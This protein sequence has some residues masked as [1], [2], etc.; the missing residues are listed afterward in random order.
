MKE[1][2][3][4]EERKRVKREINFLYIIEGGIDNISNTADLY[5]LCDGWQCDLDCPVNFLC[6]SVLIRIS[7][8][9]KIG[10][11]NKF[12]PLIIEYL[13]NKRD[14]L[15]EKLEEHKD[16]MQSLDESIGHWQDNVEKI[17]N[18]IDLFKEIKI[19][20]NSCSLCEFND[21]ING[22]NSCIVKP[23]CS[24]PES[25]WY[26]VNIERKDARLHLWSLHSAM[27]DMLKSLVRLRRKHE[28]GS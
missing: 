4:A 22:C 11:Y 26:I 24:D 20:S 23:A 2:M 21:D 18:I 9:K 5:A 28:Q 14:K 25:P 6:S 7:D 10:L 17:E 12:R 15:S 3:S 13:A 8:L 19:D 1:E 16:Q 27:E